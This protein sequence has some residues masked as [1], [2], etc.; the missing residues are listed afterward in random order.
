MP[1]KCLKNLFSVT[2]S[3]SSCSVTINGKTYSGRNIQINN[4]R[5]SI[6]G[7]ADESS[8]LKEPISI[9]I[10]GNCGA[11]ECR[12]ANIKVNGNVQGDIATG[13][14]DVECSG[15]VTGNVK[16]GAGDIECGDVSGNVQTG[17][18]DIECGKVGGS[19]KTG[20]GSVEIS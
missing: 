19:A 17:A 11:I 20:F 4:G 1:L 14:G 10:N 7:N 8:G 12:E 15:V 6:D 3:G 9:V 18:G 16:T 5:V 13:A 2:S